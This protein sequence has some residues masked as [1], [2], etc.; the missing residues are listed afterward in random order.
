MPHP[1]DVLTG[2][3][4]EGLKQ[5][6]IL[7]QA[8]QELRSHGMSAEALSRVEGATRFI[9]TEVRSHNELEEKALF[10]IV[11][12]TPPLDGP[13]AVMRQEHLELWAG[14]DRLQS[15]IA[16]IKDNPEDSRRIQ[17]IVGAAAFVVDYLRNHI[18]KEN[19]ILYPSA[20]SMLARQQWQEVAR[21]MGIEL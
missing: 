20:R 15:A 11:E 5:L 18:A 6:D 14:L 4:E 10:P 7:E 21:R 16:A 12:K 9:N 13:C 19:N 17:E 1:I 3:H 8:S 2:H